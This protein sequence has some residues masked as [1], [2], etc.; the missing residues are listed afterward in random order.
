M[1]FEEK[2]LSSP[3]T[4]HHQPGFS[5]Y[6]EQSSPYVSVASPSR[7][8]HQVGEVGGE[9]GEGGEGGGE[10]GTGGAGGCSQSIHAAPIAKAEGVEDGQRDGLR[11]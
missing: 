2:S 4:P 8:W 9:G 3:S 1:V 5:V 7:S 11:T 6:S 10:G